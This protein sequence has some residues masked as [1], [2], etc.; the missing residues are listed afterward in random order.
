MC[1][2]KEEIKMKKVIS[3]VA[4]F[5]S[6]LFIGT[7][8]YAAGDLTRQK[9]I[10]IE[11]EVGEGVW[12]PNH[13]ELETGKLYQFILKNNS[14]SKIDVDAPN[15]VSKIF[16]RKVQSYAMTEGEM[17]RTAEIKGNITELEI[18][19]RQQIDWWFVPLRTTR[20]PIKVCCTVKDG[21][22]AATIE[23]K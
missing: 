18:F 15:L 11:V 20:S 13:F 4:V 16:T 9:P 5:L 12:K 17:K 10:V 6:L 7:P 1:L 14:S 8:S 21:E 19:A 22:V 3:V 23:I 2:N